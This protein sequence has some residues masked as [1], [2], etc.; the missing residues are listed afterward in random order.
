[1]SRLSGRTAREI[2]LRERPSGVPS[3][4]QFAVVPR[5]L[6]ALRHGEFL[7]RNK[8]LSIDPAM[9]PP[10]SNGATRLD[11]AIA[12]LALGEVIDSRNERF[13]AGVT[14]LHRQGLRDFAISDGG[15]ANIISP[16]SEPLA[17]HLGP[18]GFTGFTAYAGLFEIAMLRP[19]ETI[20][21]SAAAG[22]VG[23]IAAQI[24]RQ[25]GC[26][27]I[28]SAGSEEKCE[29]LLSV[30]KVDA[31][32]NYNARP[33]RKSLKD[34]APDG[35]DVYLDNVGGSHLEA[36][37][38]RM[39]PHGRVAICGMISAYNNKGALSEAVTTLPTMMYNRITMRAYIWE[40]HLRLWPQFSVAMQAWLRS[41][42][43][44]AEDTIFTGLE[45]APQALIGL[46]EGKNL[47][48]MIVQLD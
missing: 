43:V 14:V 16:G 5:E 1:M 20:F 8:L 28:G 36:V 35:I 6:A 33:L 38:P 32:I 17:W 31:A 2:H 12:S 18:L 29:W 25:I 21:I 10:L 3:L 22:A 23:G 4:G 44:V 46:F 39:R 47:G 40:D 27:V 42:A 13:P 30:A 34:A 45:S 48:K 24:A 11:S 41:G 37:L 9:R 19:G 26:R 15:G 7:V